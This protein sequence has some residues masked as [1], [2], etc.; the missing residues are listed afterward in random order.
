MLEHLDLIIYLI[1]Y[2]CQTNSPQSSVLTLSPHSQSPST[3]HPIVRVQLVSDALVWMSLVNLSG[4]ADWVCSRL[5]SSLGRAAEQESLESWSRGV[6]G[7]VS[8]YPG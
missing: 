8:Y 1:Y 4:L 5:V 3:Q 7:A 6:F 2:Q